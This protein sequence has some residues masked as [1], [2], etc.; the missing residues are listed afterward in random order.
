M[1]KFGILTL[2]AISFFIGAFKTRNAFF[3]DIATVSFRSLTY[4][5]YGRLKPWESGSDST[6]KG[7]HYIIS[8]GSMGEVIYTEPID[9][10]GFTHLMYMI[11]ETN[12]G[13]GTSAIDFDTI[14]SANVMVEMQIGLHAQD[15]IY[16]TTNTMLYSKPINLLN[17]TNVVDRLE[18]LTGGFDGVPTNGLFP[19]ELNTVASKVIFKV[20]PVHNA[21]IST[22]TSLFVRID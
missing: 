6:G 3:Q 17:N 10:K 15:L 21:I 2:I 7:Y 16:D 18:G 20:S 12:I 22:T 8:S 11:A 1:K 19:V 9:A 4:D 14:S 5:D 13:D